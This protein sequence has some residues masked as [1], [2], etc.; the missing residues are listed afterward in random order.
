MFVKEDDWQLFRK[1]LPLWQ[2]A[3][4]KRVNAEYIEI[5]KSERNEAE[6]FWL[7]EQRISEDVK[8][9]GVCVRVARSKMMLSLV[10]LVK[11]DVIKLSDLEGFSIELIE[12]VKCWLRD[13]N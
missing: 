4:I 8:S 10:A 3:Y 11:D 12:T 5:L 6:K 13:I 9:S 2:S 1:R 7:L